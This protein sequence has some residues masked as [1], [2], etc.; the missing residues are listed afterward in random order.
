MYVENSITQPWWTITQTVCMPTSCSLDDL[1]QV[2]SYAHLPNMRTSSF[3]KEAEL[4]DLKVI[5]GNYRF[6]EDFSFYVF[7]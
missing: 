2:M 3:V 5:D 1:R 6:Y 7:V 4:I